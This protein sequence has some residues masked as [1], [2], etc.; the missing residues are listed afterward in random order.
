MF[1][2][3]PIDGAAAL[4]ESIFISREQAKSGKWIYFLVGIFICT[5]L[6]KQSEFTVLRIPLKVT[7]N[8]T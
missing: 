4:H 8:R 5:F 6:S 3:S 2:F 7:Q 1:I